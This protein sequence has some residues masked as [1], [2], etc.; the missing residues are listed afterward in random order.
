MSGA[1]PPEQGQHVSTTNLYGTL[2]RRISVVVGAAVAVGLL[3]YVA[4]APVVSPALAEVS[5]TTTSSSGLAAGAVTASSLTPVIGTST[6]STTSRLATTSRS[7]TRV[8][9]VAPYAFGTTAYN[10]WWARYY[11]VTKYRWKTTT[12]FQCLAN[13]WQRES[14]WK[15][16]SHNRYSG[17]HG[18]PQALPGSKMATAGSD[19]RTNPKTQI[20]WGLSY[21]KGR[22]GSPCGAWNS[23][24][25][26]GWY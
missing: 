11:M 14:N 13:L 22:Y 6:T 1:S 19:W 17:A 5:T 24:K 21:I 3:A 25:Y 18:I 23:F 10:K 4:P 9:A 12:Q 15:H 8:P 7:V 26:K 20:R 16:T 2:P